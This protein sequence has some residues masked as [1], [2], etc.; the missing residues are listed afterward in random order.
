MNEPE[1]LIRE[2]TKMR[3]KGAATVR[4][5]EKKVL[6]LFFLLLILSCRSVPPQPVVPRTM[7]VDRAATENGGR[8]DREDSGGGDHIPWFFYGIGRGY[9]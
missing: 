5:L 1:Y 7:P 2:E 8:F 4:V 9:I 6:F 3:R